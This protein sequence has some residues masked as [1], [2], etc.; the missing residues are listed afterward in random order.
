MTQEKE[1]K[2]IIKRNGH[3][4][5]KGKLIALLAQWNRFEDLESPT[6]RRTNEHR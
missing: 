2:V 5:Y 1:F 4:L 3:I 6:K